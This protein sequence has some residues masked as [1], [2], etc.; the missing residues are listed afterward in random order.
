LPKSDRVLGGGRNIYKIDVDKN[1]IKVGKSEYE[2]VKKKLRKI[3][4][5]LFLLNNLDNR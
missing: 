1:Q 5:F 2:K 3:I 4:S